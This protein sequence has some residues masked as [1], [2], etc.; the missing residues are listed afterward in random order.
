MRY[1]RSTEMQDR[2]D[3]ARER[4]HESLDR[5][6]PGWRE[7]KAE[8]RQEAGLAQNVGCRLCSRR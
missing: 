2:I 7:I 1:Q 6:F 4:F 8:R 5:T 3:A